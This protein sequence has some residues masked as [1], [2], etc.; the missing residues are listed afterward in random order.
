MI[1]T[2]KSPFKNWTNAQLFDHLYFL[3]SKVY[4]TRN[5][6]MI[7]EIKEILKSR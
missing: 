6:Y 1:T 5:Q 3:E 7:C 2:L 4:S